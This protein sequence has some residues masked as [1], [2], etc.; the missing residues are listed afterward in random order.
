MFVTV[1][2][3][4]GLAVRSPP[5]QYPDADYEQDWVTLK[6]V[7]AMLTVSYR[8]VVSMRA[9]IVCYRSILRYIKSSHVYV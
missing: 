2:Y 1:L 7:E 5:R 4:D 3:Y 6:D 9:S 8:P